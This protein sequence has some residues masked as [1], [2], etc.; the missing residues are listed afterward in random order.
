MNERGGQELRSESRLGAGG[1]GDPLFFPVFVIGDVKKRRSVK[2][3]Y[4]LLIRRVRSFSNHWLSAA[5]FPPE[6][7][8]KSRCLI[9]FL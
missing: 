3:F 1:R 9:F 2:F 7:L 4:G 8:E 5:L 6:S